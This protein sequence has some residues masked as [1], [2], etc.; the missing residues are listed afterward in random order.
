MPDAKPISAQTAY[1]LMTLTALFWGG[2]FVIGRAATG[3]IPPLTL[4]WVRWTGA[5]LL[6]LPFV[7]HHLWRDRTLIRERWR[8]IFLLGCIGAGLFNTLQYVSL[9]M[10]TAVTGAIINS[11]GPVL[12]AIACWLILGER[13]RIL[14][15]LGIILSLA[16]V[17]YVVARGDLSQL[18]PLGQSLGEIIMLIGLVAW[19]VY[20]ALLRFRPPISPLSF[21]AAT[22]IVASLVNTPLILLE[23]ASG[24]TVALTTPTLLAISYVAIFPSLLAY[25]FFNL[26]VESIGGARASAFFHLTP[27]MTAALGMAFLGETFEVYHVAGFILIVAGIWL[28]ARGS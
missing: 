15:V 1:L 19:G 28:T 10:M 13:L 20:T 18:P 11:A 16:G 6:V 22:Y 7:A 9:T 2:N 14:Q 23:L 12:I 27:P 21:A 26:A 8:F 24:A 17:L 3:T 4:A 25:L 5:S